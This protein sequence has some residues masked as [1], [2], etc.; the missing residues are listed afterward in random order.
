MTARLL[1]HAR[2]GRRQHPVLADPAALVR[3]LGDVPAHLPRL[4]RR[5]AR[6]RVPAARPAL[7]ALGLR[8]A[9]R[10]RACLAELEPDPGRA[11][12][13]TDAQRIVGRARTNLEFRGADE[14]LADLAPVL[15]SLERT[16]SQVNDAVSRRYFRQTA[17]VT[18]V[19]EA[20]GGRVTAPLRSTAGGCGSSTRPASTTPGRSASSYNE[21]RMS[22]RNEPRQAVL[23]ARV[24]VWPAG[25]HLP[26]RGLLGHHGHRVRRA[27][28][29]RGAGGDRDVHGGDAA[30]RRPARTRRR[31]RL[32]RP[33]RAGRPSTAGT[34][35]C[36]R[37][38]APPWT[39]S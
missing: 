24:E 4:A 8:R 27:R 17:A 30:G 33:G 2:A 12:V 31:R 3:R 16:C 14:L 13:G 15:A 10:R 39:T 34:S 29:A 36:C 35:C 1:S 6:R 21:A 19:S 7:P 26:V 25:P 5:P 32:G 22:P 23:D 20:V 9:V 37:P 11:G 28:P 18:W 38:R